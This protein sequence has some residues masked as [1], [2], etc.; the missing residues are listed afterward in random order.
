[1]S[2]IIKTH[3]HE[4][5][6][7]LKEFSE[8]SDSTLLYKRKPITSKTITISKESGNAIQQKSDGLYVADLSS[9]ILKTIFTSEGVH[10]LRYYNSKL[11]Y[12]NNS[13]A[14][15]S[16]STGGSSGGGIGDIIISPS[17]NNVLTKYPNGYYV[18]GFVISKQT[19]NALQKLSDGYYVRTIP[20]N[21]ATTDDIDAA[22]DEIDDKLIEQ[23]Q[24]F[25]ERY[26]ILTTKIQ[27]IAANTTRFQVH[28]FSGSNSISI[29]SVIDISTLYSLSNNV[30]LN[31]E[32]V[33]KN[34]SST[35]I[36]TIQILENNIE[37][38]NDTLTKS[39]VQRYKLP[40]IP[41]IEI[42]IKGDYQLFLYVTYI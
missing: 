41:T 22:I 18:P 42:F 14:W 32:L 9:H 24:T 39:E 33:I 3:N 36:L 17:E 28:E 38:L 2:S 16:I 25:N 34:T 4:N 7:I 19:N 8:A 21:N 6:N 13:G 31:L 30:I 35:D 26:D 27:Q 15:I 10:G 5:Y 12:K 29:E 20:A 23:N 11:Q 40:N 37:T 1:M